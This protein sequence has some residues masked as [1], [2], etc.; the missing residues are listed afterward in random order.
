MIALIQ[1]NPATASTGIVLIGPPP[2]LPEAWNSWLS[3]A[4]SASG[5]SAV[6]L[7]RHRKFAPIYSAVCK[8]VANEKGVPFIDMYDSITQAAG[9]SEDRHLEPYF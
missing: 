6:P 4:L 7:D 1:S 3:A 5:V 9:G 8:E 2:V